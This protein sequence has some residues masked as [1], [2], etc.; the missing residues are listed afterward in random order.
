MTTNEIIP[1]YLFPEWP[2]DSCEYFRQERFAE[3][4]SES[5]EPG[6]ALVLPRKGRDTYE[7]Q[8]KRSALKRASKRR[9]KRALMEALKW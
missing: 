4:C 3:D 7:P 1:A 6:D 2:D 9:A 8:W 5:L